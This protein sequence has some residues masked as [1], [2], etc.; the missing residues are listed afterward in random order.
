MEPPTGRAEVEGDARRYLLPLVLADDLTEGLVVI[1][2]ESRIRY[3]NPAMT[4]I[5]G[6]GREELEGESL[7]ILMP[8]E[9]RARHREAL[10]RYLATGTRTRPW[11]EV[12]LPGL[13]RSGHELDLRISFS[14]FS[15][16][17]ERLFAGTIRDVTAAEGPEEERR[18]L[19]R[20]YRALFE[21][22]V[23]AVFRAAPEGRILAA[24]GALARMVG[25]EAPEEILGRT[26]TDLFEADASRE[27][28]RRALEE[29]RQVR[30]REL[31]LRRADGSVQW[32]LVNA[33]WVDDPA[34]REPE[35]LVGTV[36]DIS[37]RRRMELD[38]RLSRERYRRLF[39]QDLIGVFRSRPGPGGRIVECNQAI[40]DMFGYESPDEI[41]GVPAGRFYP[42]GDEERMETFEAL[43]DTGMSIEY[44]LRLQRR[45]GT[46]IW[47]LANSQLVE[48]SD[49]GRLV[50]GLLFD[51]TGR[52][53][54][55]QAL[56]RARDKFRG[57][58]DISPVALKIVH[59]E[60]DEYLDVNE[61]F[62]EMFGYGRRELVEGPVT[63]DALWEDPGERRRVYRRVQ[64]GETVRSAEV[65][66]RR[67]NGEV[68]HALFSAS[69]LRLDGEGFLVAALQDISHL[70]A[71]ERELEHRSLHDP[72]T[73]LPNR[74][75]FWDR[76]NHALER[77]QR[78]GER[79]AVFF[80]DLD[81][82]KRIN[83]EHGHGAG[84]SVLREI[85]GRLAS[86]V[87]EADTVA[88]LGGD[89]F[90]VLLEDLD[91]EAD[92][93]EAARRL[94]DQFRI[95]VSVAGEEAL[96]RVSCGIAFA[97]GEGGPEGMTADELVHRADRAM[98]EAKEEP[99]S[100][101]R[102]SDPEIE[103]RA[104][105]RLRREIELKE[106][107]EREEVEPHFQ[108][109]VD[110]EDG[111]IVGGEALARWI[112]P[113]R[114]HVS[115]SEFIPLA[116]ETGLI[117]DLGRQI[118]RAAC[119]QLSRWAEEGVLPEGFRLHVNLSARELDRPDIV[120]VLDALFREAGVEPEQVTFE[121]TESVAVES[122]GVLE[123]IRAHGSPV[124]VDDFGTQYA[125]LERL[126]TLRLDSLKL[127]RLFVERI[128]ISSRHE[129][130]LEASLTLAE[131]MGLAPVAEGVETG[132]QR[133]WLR[134]RG[135]RHAQGFLFSPA[136]SAAAFGDYLR[137][138]TRFPG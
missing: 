123:T 34:D 99:G 61:S 23:A 121:V 15:R 122:S 89:E 49:G 80:V 126:A 104:T 118:C 9:F 41:V 38:L 111:R 39:E 91:R 119:F 35:A 79:I 92:A 83:D 133:A 95:P 106:A 32:S 57:V 40:A 62:Q 60:T 6:Y 87:R 124:A 28:L 114:G 58:F 16:W 44:E 109:I 53:R 36:V 66:L 68:F 30:N 98:Y 113:E 138:G 12:A 47:V 85:A 82:F 1:D 84:D 5:F 97:G 55:R 64:E 74:T 137:D 115:P 43:R 130:V 20:S 19:A 27:E 11:S 135:C 116:E 52:V 81:R 45:D 136:V 102:V 94:T 77:S 54:A 100:S 110:I 18:I 17:D 125:T 96:V 73:G 50:E 33:V 2:G 24:N 86:S 59:A 117:V 65:R 128:G 7:T 120:E 70:K 29:H 103:G 88:R 101:Y 132:E 31:E 67:K 112:H 48:E 90:G 71:V 37:D 134:E 51:I 76:L 8:E 107:L 69:E 108:P 13:H 4:R 93:E 22:D 42:G 105:G 129:A 10:R 21:N 63:S 56:E 131:A 25:H 75:L 127:D 46:P 14:E 3:A 72:L 78:T 26:V